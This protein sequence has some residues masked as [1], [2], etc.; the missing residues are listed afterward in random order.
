[1]KFCFVC[2][3][4][5]EK[6]IEGYCED[7]Y[8][9]K[10]ELI[11]VPKDMLLKVCSKCNRINYRNVWRDMSIEDILK[12]KI[13]ILGKNVDL[14]ISRNDNVISVRAKGFLKNS[15]KQK[16][17]CYNIRLKINKVV[18]PECSRRLGDYYEAIL[19][20]RGDANKMFDF[21]EDKLTDKN[22]Y[23]VENVRN[24]IDI[25]LNDSHIAE[26]MSKMLKKRFNS[27]VKKSFRLLTKK[28]GKDIYRST[29]VVRSG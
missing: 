15:K 4:N 9:K 3:K 10:F 19:Q 24:G 23:K 14:K 11:K 17:E 28:Q 16:E 20:L 29:F 22:I 7:C 2:G 27:K 5:T 8:N 1:M 12:D 21:L 25:Y 13:K 26:N 18:C 6:L